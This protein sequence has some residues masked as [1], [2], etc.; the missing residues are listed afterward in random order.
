M[1]LF[2]AQKKFDFEQPDW[3]KDP[4][5]YIIHQI[6]EQ[7]TDII[8]LATACF[9]NIKNRQIG[10]TGLTLEQAVRCAI[11]QQI[12]R[13]K[14]RELSLHTADSK[15]CI[16]FTNMEYGQRFSH[17]TLQE[18]ISKITPD[19]LTQI[20]IEIGKMAIDLG[21]DTGKKLR[22]DSTAIETNIHHPTNCSLL[23][24]CV[25]VSCRILKDVKTMF[26]NIKVSIYSKKTA[27]K[28]AYTIVNTRGQE[29]RIPLFKKMLRIQLKFQRQVVAAIDQLESVTFEEDELEN[30]R[31][32]KLDE[33]TA[34]LAKMEKVYSA[35][36]RKEMLGE[37]VPV[38][39][40]LFSIFE[41]HTDC[42][43]K[44]NRDVIFGHKVNFTTGKSG[45]I[46]DTI[47]ERGNPSDIGFYGKTLDNMKD[48]YCLVPRDF[49]T[50][51]GFAS[52]EN[53]DDAKERGIENIVFAKT[54]GKLQNNVSSKKMETMLKKWRA[55]IEANISN[56]KR[57]LDAG[58]ATWK[59]YDGF[60]RFVLWSVIAYNLK[61]LAALLLTSL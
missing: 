46:F 48:N 3:S 11:Y 23:W 19:V 21:V 52:I 8:R 4:E 37:K 30:E 49:A 13:L 57:G 32:Q 41:D 45:I 16:V 18:V 34:L 44:G 14:C 27:K 51:G 33:L 35:A 42:I 50:D 9:P 59:G 54:K 12:K 39:E 7:R 26:D 40:K 61:M 10:R 31:Q 2:K 22:S 29:K 15:I 36:Y 58:R 25:R 47:I 17:Q 5:L 38:D 1:L 28:L 24:D 43:K 6:L 60:E 55:G 20:T 53:M 56:F